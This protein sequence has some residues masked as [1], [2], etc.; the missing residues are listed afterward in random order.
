MNDLVAIVRKYVPAFELSLANLLW[1]SKE[2]FVEVFSKNRKVKTEKIP[3]YRKRA[4][5]KNIDDVGFT[6]VRKRANM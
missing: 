2:R 4:L 5:S 3:G 1:D 6:L